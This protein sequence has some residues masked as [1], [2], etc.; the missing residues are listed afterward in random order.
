MGQKT[1]MNK[2]NAGAAVQGI[3]QSGQQQWQNSANKGAICSQNQ[4]ACH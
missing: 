3:L 2:K 1:E 4:G